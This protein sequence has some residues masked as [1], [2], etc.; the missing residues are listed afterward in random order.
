[1]YQDLNRFS[2]AYRSPKRFIGCS[3]LIREDVNRVVC[4]RLARGDT[5]CS[6][7]SSDPMMTR[8][9]PSCACICMYIYIYIYIHM[10]TYIQAYMYTVARRR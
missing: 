4:S 1:M 5:G 10:C 3:V 8:S 7:L 9:L 2:A 6:A